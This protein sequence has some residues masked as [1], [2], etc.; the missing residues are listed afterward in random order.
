MKN[1]LIFITH[2][3]PFGKKEA[4]IEAEYPILSKHFDKIIIITRNITDLDCRKIDDNTLVYKN[5]PKT[6]GRQWFITFLITLINIPRIFH[7]FF[8][9]IK[10]RK[11]LGRIINNTQKKYLIKR[12]I[13]SLELKHFINTI[14]RKNKISGKVIYYSYWLSTGAT[15]V[16]MIKQ[17]KNILRISRAHRVDLYEYETEC[18]Y[19]PLAHYLFNRLDAIFFISENGKKYFSSLI[20]KSSNKLI[21]SKL[22]VIESKCLPSINNELIQIVSCSSLIA[23]K[24]IHLII[25]VISQLKTD[26]HI[27]WIH[28]GDGPLKGEIEAYSSKMFKRNNNISYKFTGHIPNREVLNF[29]ENNFVN[30]FINLSISEGIPVSIMEAIAYGIQVIATDVG[31]T[32]EIV[33]NQTGILIPKNY[34]TSDIVNRIHEIINLES[35]SLSESRNKIIDFWKQN[36]D[37]KKNYEDFVKKLNSISIQ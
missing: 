25:D 24:R 34:S 4:F 23:V 35:R 5:N 16:S 11:G 12:I 2:H 30:L 20:K 29:Y 17:S 27:N 32:S 6:K 13:K 19:I 36:Y 10:Y 21:I 18:N 9:E 14:V 31:G 22:G 26:K 15:A 28:F 1:T 3:F 37:A 8:T 33:N 7:L